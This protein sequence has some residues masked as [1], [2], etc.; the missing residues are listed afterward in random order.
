MHFWQRN[1]VKK[2]TIAKVKRIYYKRRLSRSMIDSNQ[3]F[4]VVHLFK[5]KIQDWPA[6]KEK[7]L[8]KVTWK[9]INEIYQARSAARSYGNIK[10]QGT[11]KLVIP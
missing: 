7:F 10:V 3:E 11:Y 8:A 9:Q 6:W 4:I 1:C 2:K 5:G